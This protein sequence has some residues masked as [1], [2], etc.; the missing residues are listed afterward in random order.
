MLSLF[1]Y[2]GIY[3]IHFFVNTTEKPYRTFVFGVFDLLFFTQ[4]NMPNNL[5]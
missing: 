3:H 5:T 2:I 4:N 1:E